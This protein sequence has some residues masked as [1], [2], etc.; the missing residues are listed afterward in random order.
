MSK[1]N[2]N[3]SKAIFV[4]LA[5]LASIAWASDNMNGM[6]MSNMDMSNMKGMSSAAHAK[7]QHNHTKKSASGATV[8]K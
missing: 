7:M 1:V 2:F 5:S 3:F 4:I 6:D 8:Q